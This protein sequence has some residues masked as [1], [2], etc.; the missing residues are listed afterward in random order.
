MVF[1]VSIRL[2]LFEA[3]LLQSDRGFSAQ[4]RP[5]Q[6]LHD[7]SINESTERHVSVHVQNGGENFFL[8]HTSPEPLCYE[9]SYGLDCDCKCNA[10]QFDAE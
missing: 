8:L 1:T 7:T 10:I 2:W 3:H 5:K 6:A 4:A 9:N